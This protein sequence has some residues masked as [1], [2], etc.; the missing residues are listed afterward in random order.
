MRVTNSERLS[1]KVTTTSGKMAGYVTTKPGSPRLYLDFRRNGFRSEL[2]TGL[3]NSSDNQDYAKEV[4]LRTL[5]EIESGT[6]SFAEAFPAASDKLKALHALYDRPAMLRISPDSLTFGAYVGRSDDE[7]DSWRVRI[8]NKYKSVSKQNDYRRALDDRLLEYFGK[9]T[10]IQIHGVEVE[11]FINSLKWRGTAK[12]GQDL[13]VSSVRNL[14]TVLSA[15][16]LS[17]RTEH[18]WAIA[19]PFDYVRKKK[20]L[21]QRVKSHPTVLRFG[22]WALILSTIEA[23]Y[24]PIA[25]LFLLTGMMA[26]EIA[27][28]RKKDIDAGHIHVQNKCV[29]TGEKEELKNKYRE[30]YIPIT[31]ALRTVL[32]TLTA[33]SDGSYVVVMPDGQR[34]SHSKFK[35]TW[36]AALKK[37]DLQYT[38]PYTLRHTFAAWA[39]TLNIDINKLERLMGHGS[40]EMLYETYGKYVDSLEDDFDEILHYFGK[41]FLSK[42]VKKPCPGQVGLSVRAGAES[43]PCRPAFRSDADR[44]SAGKPTAIPVHADRDFDVVAR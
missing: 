4:L 11:A 22:N 36:A 2:S 26:S 41:D 10:F 14:L 33:R 7:K 17:A 29:P 16:L 44:D 8:L 12:A 20:L 6:F 32:D 27:G 9:K 28:L 38:R 34:Y 24:R 37:S 13:S 1:I 42:E 31:A 18:Y 39:M 43:G 21:P 25:E 3:P 19:D 5:T 15:V 40:K 35:D 23:Y 30:R